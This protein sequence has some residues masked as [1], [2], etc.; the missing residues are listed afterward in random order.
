[1]LTQKLKKL[2]PITLISLLI[3]LLVACLPT[4]E[5]GDKEGISVDNDTQITIER[6]ACFGT[7][8]IY[9]ATIFG[10][11]RVVYNGADFVTVDS[12]QIKNIDPQDVQDLVEF[13]VNNGYRDLQDNYTTRTVTD[14]PS[15]I[16]SLTINGETKRI[17]RYEGDESAPSI[18]KQIEDRI[19]AVADVGEWTGQN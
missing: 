13:M 7:C 12:E 17:E 9:T 15:A 4:E 11:G 18:L 8:P 16:T 14:M 3:M 1:M 19:D 10:D 2:F 5:V 6:T